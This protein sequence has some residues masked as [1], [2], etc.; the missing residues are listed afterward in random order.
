MDLKVHGA[1]VVRPLHPT[2]KFIFQF[3]VFFWA[4]YTI[5]TVP[6]FSPG[7]EES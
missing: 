7:S 4:K 5:D 2:A 3:Q 6:Q 1:H